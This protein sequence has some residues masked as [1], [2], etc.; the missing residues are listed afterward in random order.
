[1]NIQDWEI[2]KVLSNHAFTT[3]RELSEQS[4]YSLGLVNRILKNLILQG[5]LDDSM[6]LTQMAEME[7]EKKKPKNAIILAAGYGMRMV[8]LN[9]ETPKGLLEI[10]GERLIE[11]IIHQL[12][13]SGITEIYV[14]VGFLKEKYEYLMD[15]FG[16]EL[17]VNQDYANKN[18]LHSLNRALKYLSNT[19]IVPCDIWCRENPF[20]SKEL[21]SWYMVTDDMSI[22]S[23]VRVNRKMELVPVQRDELGNSM[24]GISYLCEEQ[25]LIVRNCVERFCNN[26]IYD[27]EF[28]EI[29]LY[30][31]DRMMVFAKVVDAASVYE[32]NTFEQLREIDSNSNQLKA[33]ALAVIAEVFCT[34]QKNIKDI[35]VLKK[36]MT[37]RS[38]CFS[39]DNQRYI[40]RIPGSGTEKLINR[41]EEQNV[42][43]VVRKTGLCDEIIYINAQQGYKITK[44]YEHTRVCDPFD[45]EDVNRC[46]MMLRQF[47]SQ[48]LKVKHRFDIFKQINFYEMLWNGKESIYRDYHSTKECV[49]RL[50]NYI[51]KYKEEEVLTHIDAI[52]DNFLF[53]ETAE[54][55]SEIKLIDWEYAG[56][57]DPHVDIAM[58]CIYALYDR[59][60]ID[61]VIDCYFNNNC[62]IEIRIKIYCYIAA[63]GLLWSNWCEYKSN[64]GSE[65]GEYAL[66]QYRYAKDYYRIVVK[67]YK[68]DV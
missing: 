68:I 60:Y 1:M 21:Y 52:P 26:R 20:S 12:N 42:Y 40:M 56:M 38:F 41:F 30:R 45:S 32:I 66:R 50:K 57:Q 13:E 27:H 10:K 34:N 7:F 17:I 51:E 24:I 16:V 58:F 39:I 62:S 59:R 6:Q 54:G 8:P 61:E 31:N 53:V 11:R 15:E 49:F 64:L 5:Y 3:Q 47:H 2:I 14:V 22:D 29:A 44:Y 35:E 9:T 36:G 65:F 37:N 28:W 63:C 55:S 33:D 67:E 18:N 48:K 4:G 23:D 46:M 43:E 19:Y 25:A